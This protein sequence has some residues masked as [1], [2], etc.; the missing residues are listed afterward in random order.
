MLYT[1][2]YKTKGQPWTNHPEVQSSNDRQPIALIAQTMAKENPGTAT[3]VL[4]T[5]A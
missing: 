1:L 3:R 2:Q 4:S 5:K